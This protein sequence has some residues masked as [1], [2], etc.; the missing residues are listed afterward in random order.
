MFNFWKYLTD[1][2]VHI[3]HEEWED[4]CALIHHRYIQKWRRIPNGW[5]KVDTDDYLRG[6]Y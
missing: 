5:R 3:I 6:K 2:P 1:R 4:V